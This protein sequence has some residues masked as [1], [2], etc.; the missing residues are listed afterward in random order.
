MIVTT[1]NEIYGKTITEYLGVVFGEVVDFAYTG[2]SFQ[3][4][5][6]K[7][8]EKMVQEKY[9]ALYVMKTNA[10]K[11]GANAIVGVSFSFDRDSRILSVSATGTA[12]KIV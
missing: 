3:Q 5:C 9:K 4:L 11:I 12:V 8:E 7:Y 6:E 10:E 1:T 2:W